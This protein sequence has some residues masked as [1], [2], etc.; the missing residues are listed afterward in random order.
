MARPDIARSFRR[1]PEAS[2]DIRGAMSTRIDGAAIPCW[3][4]QV[5]GPP[6]MAPPDHFS[7]GLKYSRCGGELCCNVH[8]FGDARK[9]LTVRHFL[10]VFCFAKMAP[11]GHQARLSRPNM[12]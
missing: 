9:P 4:M 8:H 6:D 3:C 11:I 1:V 5:A 12:L 7:I 10:G 2:P